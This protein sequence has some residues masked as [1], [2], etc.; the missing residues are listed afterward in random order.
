MTV[1][2]RASI[3]GVALTVVLIGAA[4][5]WFAFIRDERRPISSIRQ[6]T[7][8]ELLV[9][10][11]KLDVTRHPQVWDQVELTY[12]LTL[13]GKFTI[14]GT[15]PITGLQ[16]RTGT[17]Q[18]EGNILRL[19]AV[20]APKYP[21]ETWELTIEKLTEEELVTASE[22]DSMGRQERDYFQRSTGK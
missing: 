8:T 11:W 18:L 19:S 13:D 15:D 3:A 4:A 9:G 17:Y 22:R 1:R 6:K 16:V 5:T 10:T 14:R 20:A 7:M 2:S 21:A 12:E